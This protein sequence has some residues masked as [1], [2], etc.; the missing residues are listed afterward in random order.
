MESYWIYSFT[1]V[2][3]LCVSGLCSFYWWVVCHCKDIL[4]F[5]YLL[6]AFRICHFDRRIILIQ[7]RNGNWE[8][9]DTERV[10]YPPSVCL[11]TTM[12]HVFTIVKVF[13]LPSLSGR[14]KHLLSLDRRLALRWVY[15]T[16]ITKVTF[17]FHLFPLYV[18][19]PTIYHP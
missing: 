16:N 13:P 1:C 12:G 4:Q 9:A 17:I 5:V 3:V 8:T 10:P 7:V 14:E 11:K 18:Y 15:I 2:P 19:L 6:K